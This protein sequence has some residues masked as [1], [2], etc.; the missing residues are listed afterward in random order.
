MIC[1]HGTPG[2]ARYCGLC[3]YQ[4]LAEADQLPPRLKRDTTR[5]APPPP[6]FWDRV[7]RARAAARTEHAPHPEQTTLDLLDHPEDS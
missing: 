1:T 4:V 7:E 2:G 3:R 6:D 5:G